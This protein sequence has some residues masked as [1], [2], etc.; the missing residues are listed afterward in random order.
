MKCFICKHRR[1]QWLLILP[2]LLL[3]Y[4]W[5]TLKCNNMLQSGTS[6]TFQSLTILNKIEKSRL[7]LIKSNKLADVLNN[8][9]PAIKIFMEKSDTQL[10]FLDFTIDKGNFYSKPADSKRYVSFKSNHHKLC[11]KIS[12]LILFVVFAWLLKK[13]LSKKLSWKT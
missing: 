4:Q 8:V 10:P 12:H 1:P 7:N 2:R 6:S 3:H 11:L 9:K 5:D 13:T